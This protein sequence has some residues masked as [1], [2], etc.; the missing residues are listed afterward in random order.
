MSDG[1]SD[2][3]YAWDLKEQREKIQELEGKFLDKPSKKE[4][5]N[6]LGLV[7]T[8]IS[9]KRDFDSWSVER[10]VEYPRYIEGVISGTKLKKYLE[11]LREG[12]KDL[13]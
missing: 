8:Y 12:E 13:S 10:L 9:T 5:K 6:I 1:L 3:N 2:Q 7:K 4:A 11:K